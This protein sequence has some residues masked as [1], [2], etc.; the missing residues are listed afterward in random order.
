M[1]SELLDISVGRF[2]SKLESMRAETIIE[3]GMGE[4]CS[5][6]VEKFLQNLNLKHLKQIG[7]LDDPDI[8]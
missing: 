5:T 3:D 6:N 1:K 4:A 2:A 7:H 8:D